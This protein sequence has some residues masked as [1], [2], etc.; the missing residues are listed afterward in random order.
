MHAY[1]NDRMACGSELKTIMIDVTYRTLN[2]PD[3]SLITTRMDV[4]QT[5]ATNGLVHEGTVWNAFYS[6][7]NQHHI[8]PIRSSDVFITYRVYVSSL[9]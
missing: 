4:S 9:K 2:E 3:F 8:W 7:G 5:R 1:E 6:C